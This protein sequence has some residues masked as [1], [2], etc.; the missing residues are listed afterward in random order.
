MYMV[1]PLRSVVWFVVDDN[2]V[3]NAEDQGVVSF[4]FST[5]MQLG[6]AGEGGRLTIRL[7]LVSWFFLLLECCGT[8]FLLALFVC[9]L[10]FV[11]GAANPHTSYESGSLL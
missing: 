6:R 10:F 2:S 3:V 5:S 11:L 9:L 1:F 8:T 4:I 7:S